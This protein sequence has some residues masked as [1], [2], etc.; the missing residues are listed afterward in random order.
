MVT[1][2]LKTISLLL[3]LV[4]T[5]T[6]SA[7]GQNTKTL[8]L[9]K[10]TPTPSAPPPGNIQLLS[11]Y[12]HTRLQGTDT[13]VGEISKPDGMTIQYDNG[14]LAGLYA[15]GCWSKDACLWYKSQKINGRE[16]WL[17]LTKEG[18]I[19]ATFPKEFANF[20]AQTKSPEDIADFLIMIMTYKA[21]ESVGAP[22]KL[23]ERKLKQ[24]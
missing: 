9:P 4:S 3:F 5:L 17:G 18:R 10:P 13:S 19:I 1:S 7:L 14:R 11:G 16:V 6:L 23:E 8:T 21:Q 20:Y 15:R 2:M 12:T 24:K 22:D